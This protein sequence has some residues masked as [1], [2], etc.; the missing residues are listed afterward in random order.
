MSAERE[1]TTNGEERLK[2]FIEQ[3]TSE[4]EAL[5]KLLDELKKDYQKASSK[6]IAKKK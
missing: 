3:K 2:S 1:K 6:E 4:N 5:K